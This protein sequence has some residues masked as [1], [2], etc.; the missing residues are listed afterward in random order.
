MTEP[1]LAAGPI[2]SIEA[3]REELRT[4][5]RAELKRG[6]LVLLTAFV[7]AGMGIGTLSGN[8]MGAMMLPIIHD[9]GWTR[10]QFSLASTCGALTSIA[11]M[12]FTG[13]LV[14]RF[15]VRRVAGLSIL[16][17]V[18]ILYRLS[19]FHGDLLQFMLLA[20]LQGLIGAGN[21]PVVYIA[22]ITS[23]FDRM[24]GFAIGVALAA[25]GVAAIITPKFIIPY[26]ARAGWRMG[27]QALAIV[28]LASLP[29][30]LLGAKRN[31]Q[32]HN[33]GTAELGMDG[34]SLQEAVRTRQ[35]W[36]LGL[37]M[38]LMGLGLSGVYL[39]LVPMMTDRGLPT[40]QI[41]QA[42]AIFGLAVLSGRLAAGY[43]L[44]RIFAP[45]VGTATLSMAIIGMSSLLI[46]SGTLHIYVVAALLG[47]AIGP[48]LDLA[49][50]ITARIFGRFAYGKIY[51]LQFCMFCIGA[52]PGTPLYGLV[53]DRT[54][55]YAYALI[56]SIV[57]LTAVIPVLFSLRRG[58]TGGRLALT[59]PR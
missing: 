28:M 34:T 26:I 30:M 33:V 10:A 5:R 9:N 7:G 11:A 37:A 16:G 22:L 14:D 18:A 23:W 56:G 24:R 1:L 38:A 17:C 13:A 57:T 51:S 32:Q 41:A 19:H 47:L 43:L 35:F 21:S 44:D 3:A 15:G 55:S 27:Y 36:R 20:A 50:Y 12:P 8:S 6:W 40:A 58:E 59:T 31:P 4:V 48:E 39:H 25:S 53:H 46:Q 49:A 52:L 54:G 29:L 42:A 2:D 45:I